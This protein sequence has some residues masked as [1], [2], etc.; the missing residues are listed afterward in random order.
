MSVSTLKG[1]SRAE[2]AELR[3]ALADQFEYLHAFVGQLGGMSEAQAAARAALY[4]GS[5]KA[6]YWRAWA[7]KDLACYPGSCE[8]C[9]G[10]CRCALDRREDG[11][12]WTGPGDAHSCEACRG[13]IGRRMDQ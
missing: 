11:V 13:R 3:A 9:Y 4:A 8:Q 12:Y 10:R 2:R 5:P 6:S 7:G 1:L